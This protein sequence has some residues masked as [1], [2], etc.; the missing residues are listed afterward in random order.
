MGIG[1]SITLIAIGAILA[2]A[3]TETSVGPVQLNVVGWILMAAGLVGLVLTLT[4]FGR[5][6]RVVEER[7]VQ[8][9]VVERDRY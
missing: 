5:R 4:V 9:E 8:R 6:R 1:G 2:F 7:P 3:L